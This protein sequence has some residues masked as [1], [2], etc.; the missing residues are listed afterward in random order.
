[1][2]TQAQETQ[3][4]PQTEQVHDGQCFCGSVRLEARGE[5]AAQGYCHCE[6]CRSMSGAPVRGFTLWPEDSVRITKGEDQLK[7]YNKT[8]F[9][10]RRH[11]ANCGGQVLINHPSI[12][13]VDVHSE[14]LRGFNFQPAVH[15]NY[16]ERTLPVR[17]GLLKLKDFP[18]ELG[19]SGEAIPE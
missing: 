3:D 15:V 2:A 10:D 6:S 7:G 8:D 12:G 14:A 4:G 5:P 19:G 11:C 9:S 17:D 13:M 1:M 18:A 16:Q